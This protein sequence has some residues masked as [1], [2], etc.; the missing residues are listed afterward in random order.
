MIHVCSLQRLAETVEA[1]GAQRVVT[2]IDIGTP[3]TRPA[4]IAVEHHLHLEIHDISFPSEGCIHPQQHHVERL[5][6]FVREWDQAAPLVVHCF[7]GISRSSAAAYV[8]ACTVHPDRDE[9]AIAKA[10]R[11]ASATACPNRL[12]VSLADRLLGREGRM[13]KAVES[14]VPHEPCLSALPFRLAFD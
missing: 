5:I 8:A 13:V 14:I 3:V 7:A 2:L 12:I 10:L 9:L 6:G 4:G 11:T 1:T